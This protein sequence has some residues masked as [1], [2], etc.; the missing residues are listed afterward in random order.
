M[1]V[2]KEQVGCVLSSS[3]S[4][5]WNAVLRGGED[6]P[7]C[8]ILVLVS[9]GVC[10]RCG[11]DGGQEAGGVCPVLELECYQNSEDT[12]V[13]INLVLILVSVAGVVVL[14]GRKQVGVSSS[15]LSCWWWN[16]SMLPSRPPVAS[17]HRRPAAAAAAASPSL[18]SLSPDHRHHQEPRHRTTHQ[19]HQ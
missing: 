16:V 5:C 8:Q 3:L 12:R 19:V 2:G 15:C 11:D 13:M 10:S 6:T 14:E 7:P 9:L 1:L 17:G 4:W 18:T